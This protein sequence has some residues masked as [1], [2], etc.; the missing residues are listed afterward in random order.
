M[1][2]NLPRSPFANM[3]PSGALTKT[4]CNIKTRIKDGNE[5]MASG[6]FVDSNNSFQDQKND[7]D[8]VYEDY[9]KLYQVEKAKQTLEKNNKKE[10]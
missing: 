6:C 3:T 9:Q 2:I 7:L 4:H 10:S 5:R 1:A 8:K